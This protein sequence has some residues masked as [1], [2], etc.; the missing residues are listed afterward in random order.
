MI[1]AKDVLLEMLSFC[2]FQQE[3]EAAIDKV[4]DILPAAI[5]AQCIPFVADVGVYAVKY[6]V[7]EELQPKQFCTLLG[8]CSKTKTVLESGKS[9]VCVPMM[10]FLLSM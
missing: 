3:I 9:I 6:L 7:E 2:N 5:K 4:C 8:L 10:Y 1:I